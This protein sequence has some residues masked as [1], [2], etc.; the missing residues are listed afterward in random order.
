MY[1]NI[2][3]LTLCTL[4]FHGSSGTAQANGIQSQGD[5]V[6]PS[7]WQIQAQDG[8]AV[9]LT[10]DA[11]EEFN[12]KIIHKSPSVYN[13]EEYPSQSD[14]AQLNTAFTASKTLLNQS[15]Y[16]H[17]VLLTPDEKKAIAQ[18]CNDDR[19]TPSPTAKG[20][21]LR[22]TNMRALPYAA[23]LFESPDDHQFDLLQETAIDPGE[24]L[25]ILHASRSGAFYYVQM[26]NYHGWIAAKD[27]VKAEPAAW[28]QFL[29]PSG[30][31]VV[32]ANRFALPIG[33]E[34]LLYQMGA[35]IPVIAEDPQSYMVA[36]PSANLAATAKIAKTAPVHY[37]YLPYTK[38]T[39]IKQSFKFLHDPYGWGGL[40]DSVDCSS[41]IADIYRTVGMELPRNADE[42][43]LTAGRYT[44]MRQMSAVERQQHF[45]S[46]QAGDV[47][48]FDGHTMLFLGM[49][50]NRPFII[51]SLGSYTRHYANGAKEKIRAMRV[52][53]SDLS[54]RR[55][56][57]RT[58]AES[59]TGTMRYQ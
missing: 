47:L 23:G 48:F 19:L 21:T 15:L 43:E 40:K 25:I 32:T 50:D 31:L 29:Q 9:R 53:V 26:R 59:M 38:N 37:G 6:T 33:S 18:E 44:D 45:S 4:L 36:L 57:G 41:F 1:K 7:F 12:T 8:D 56:N 10:G 17:G 13:L 2:L 35:K 49:Y 42:Q 54:L 27:I 16:A 14:I 24:P 34:T 51:H 11:I 20:I 39:L 28:R 58:F 5:L 3:L 46:L 22:R 55:Y 52:V 30:F